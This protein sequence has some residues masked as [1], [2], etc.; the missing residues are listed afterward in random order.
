LLR[1]QEDIAELAR[2]P[3]VYIKMSGLFI[4]ILSHQFHKQDRLASKQEIYD[5]AFPLISH[6]LRHFGSYRVIFAFNFP[7]KYLTAEHH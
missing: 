5:L 1:W 2:Y 4:P 7:I 6:V 3:N